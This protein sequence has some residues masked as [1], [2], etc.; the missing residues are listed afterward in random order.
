MLTE[1]LDKLKLT[2]SQMT[3]HTAELTREVMGMSASVQSQARLFCNA[4]KL[5]LHTCIQASASP[6][7]KR[8]MLLGS[9]TC[10]DE[11]QLGLCSMALHC[12]NDATCT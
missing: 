7:L 2:Y 11:T 5:V 12:Q 1:S 10:V 8:F 3:T 6:Y 4:E 9:S